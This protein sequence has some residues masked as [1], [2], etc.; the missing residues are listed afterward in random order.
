MGLQTI[1]FDYALIAAPRDTIFG[2]YA[3]KTGKND[4]R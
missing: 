1:S 2:M 3:H 4:I